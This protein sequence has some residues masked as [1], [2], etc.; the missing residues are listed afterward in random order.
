[1]LQVVKTRFD[2]DMLTANHR[3]NDWLS[4]IFKTSW[5]R[6]QDLSIM[7]MFL[8][9]KVSGSKPKT[10]GLLV[11]FTPWQTSTVSMGKSTVQLRRLGSLPPSSGFPDRFSLVGGAITTLKNMS[12]SMGSILQYKLWKNSKC[13]KPPTSSILA[14]KAKSSDQQWEKRVPESSDSEPQ[15]YDASNKS[16]TWGLWQVC[17]YT[18]FCFDYRAIVIKKRGHPVCI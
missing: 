6:T 4:E 18:M 9:P 10:I 13:L 1:M 2:S 17:Q 16:N 7:A 12:S 3:G 8:F 11:G 15:C 14:T 5:S